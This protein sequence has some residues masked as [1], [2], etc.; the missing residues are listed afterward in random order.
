MPEANGS[1][2][3]NSTPVIVT[4]IPMRPRIPRQALLLLPKDQKIPQTLLNALQKRGLVPKVVGDLPAVM[5]ELALKPV[6]ILVL[7]QPRAWPHLDELGRA[8]ERYYPQTPCWRF[9][10]PDARL[11][12]GRL[13]PWSWKQAVPPADIPPSSAMEPAPLSSDPAP[14]RRPHRQVPDPLLTREE[15]DML[16]DHSW[17]RMSRT[18]RPRQ[19]RDQDDGL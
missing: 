3:A 18:R 14:Q 2:S 1:T 9:H 8:L 10:L 11:T 16:L 15:L 13:E 12:H 19:P 17:E 6:S 7:T 5:V 4:S